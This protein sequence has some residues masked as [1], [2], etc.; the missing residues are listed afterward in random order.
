MNSNK[1]VHTEHCCILHG[2]KYGDE[3]CPVE[4][5]YKKQSYL[6]ESCDFGWKNTEAQNKKLW[7]EINEE[8]QRT[9]D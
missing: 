7:E 3:N 1:C 4:L 9:N 2:C 6:C 8:F 5:G